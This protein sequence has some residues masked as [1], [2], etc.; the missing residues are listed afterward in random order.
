MKNLLEICQEPCALFLENLTSLQRRNLLEGYTR[1][2][3]PVDR[4]VYVRDLP[5]NLLCFQSG[6]K[7][8]SA[9]TMVGA[10]EQDA[11]LAVSTKTCPSIPTD[12]IIS[13]QDFENFGGTIVEVCSYDPSM[14]LKSGR[15]DEITEKHEFPVKQDE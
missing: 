8:L 11:G 2:K 10:K 13:K 15:V 1:L 5:K 7:A 6:V 14:L 3:S 9:I 12:D 4:L